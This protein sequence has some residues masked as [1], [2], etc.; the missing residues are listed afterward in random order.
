MKR[1]VLALAALVTMIAMM[2]VSSAASA[3]SDVT[4]TEVSFTSSDGVTLHGTVFAPRTAT[5]RQP[6]LVLLEGAG[7][8]G[9]SYLRAE[10]E[11]YARHGVVTLAYD[12]RSVGYSLLKRDYGLLADD[13]L[14]A[15]R[16]LRTR[17]GVDPDR[18]GLWALSEGAFVAPIAAGR[19]DEVA[20]VITVG[21]V[22]V[23]PAA[24]TAWA[25]GPYLEH[26]GVTGRLARTLQTT[27]LGT[28]IDVGLFPEYDFDPVPAWER[29]RQP[30]LAQWGEFDRD[31]VPRESSRL[32]REALERGGNT[33][34]SVRIVA[35]VNH[36]L[37]TTANEGFDRLPTLP[38]GYADAEV[39]W[40]HDPS[41]TPTGVELAP[42]APTPDPVGAGTRWILVTGAVMVLG[43]L[44]FG[45]IRAGRLPKAFRWLAVLAPVSVLW[46]LCYMFFLLASAGK[47]TG[48]VVAGRPV[49]W[50]FTQLLAV[51]TV[52]AALAVLAAWHRPSKLTSAGRIRTG[53][54]TAVAALTLPWTIYWGLLWI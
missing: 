48:P 49:A 34:H 8:R 21:A 44:A 28:A 33:Q 11:A 37:H 20:F 6:G 2:V 22:G 9:R 17:Q 16:V 42:E 7:N 41:R 40:I 18:I 39:A 35:S 47:V 26:A 52:V 27:V 38:A 10:A 43:G 53:A 31:S 50:L 13:A 54:L 12:K 3:A 19:S 29:V 14:A 30:V 4:T 15:V 25:Y 23:T 32:I 1:L 51:G 24:Q 46:T 45:L 36:N 5:G